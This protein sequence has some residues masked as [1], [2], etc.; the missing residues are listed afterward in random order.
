MTKTMRILVIGALVLGALWLHFTLCNWHAS[1]SSAFE[2]AR[3]VGW[4]TETISV[5]TIGTR[6]VTYSGFGLFPS[7][8]VSKAEAS[9]AGVAIPAGLLVTCVLLLL[10][11][12]RDKV[13]GMG[14]CPSCLHLLDP[15]AVV[16]CPECGTVGQ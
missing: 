14:A 5:T 16:R 6:Y 11:W 15:S 4:G 3:V 1:H 10:K 12:R 13:V 7:I 8:G 9:V 2:S